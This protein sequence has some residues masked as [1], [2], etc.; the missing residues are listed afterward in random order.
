[1][2]LINRQLMVRAYS[3]MKRIKRTELKVANT[4]RNER[5]GGKL[6]NTL[7]INSPEEFANAFSDIGGHFQSFRIMCTFVQ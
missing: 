2:S 5:H 6:A 4:F 3:K 7:E 1:M